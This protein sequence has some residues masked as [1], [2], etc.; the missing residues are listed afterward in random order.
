[1]SRMP[2]ALQEKLE[3]AAV[4][5]WYAPLADEPDPKRLPLPAAM[6][7]ERMT[8][9]NARDTDPIRTAREAARG[10]ESAAAYVLVP[11]RRFD[12][13][14]TRHGRGG[15]WVDRFLYALPQAWLRIGICSMRLVS[16]ELLARKAWDEPMDW[17][18]I[19][20]DGAW[21]FVETGARTPRTPHDTGR[22]M[23]PRRGT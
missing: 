4:G 6:R 11:G 18:M 10:R 9:A 3:R 17:L 2:R 12:R 1:M 5:I 23:D 7:D 13:A 8:L 19:E 16:D 14:G 22:G 15:G 20:R 21:T